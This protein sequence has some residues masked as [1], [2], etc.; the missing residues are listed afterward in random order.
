MWGE[1]VDETNF[2]PRVWPR[3]SAV[4][5]RLWSNAAVVDLSDAESRLHRFRCSLT[6]LGRFP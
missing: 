6:S 2:L 1:H 4:A 5:E 3:A